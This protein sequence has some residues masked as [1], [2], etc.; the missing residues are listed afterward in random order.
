[1]FHPTEETRLTA[2]ATVEAIVF[3]TWLYFL[4]FLFDPYVYV[5]EVLLVNAMR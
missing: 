3:G 5:H 1:M 4:C 2:A